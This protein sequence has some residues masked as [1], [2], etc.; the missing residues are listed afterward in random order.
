[1]S[2]SDVAKA[3]APAFVLFGTSLI[4]N[5]QARKDAQGQANATQKALDTQYQI[6]LQNQQNIKSMQDAGKAPPEEKSNLPLYI[7]LGVG[8]VVILGVVIFAVT[9]K[10]N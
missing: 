7:G 2:W 6:A 1:M 5:N 4:T 10:S 3:V 8:G 9:R